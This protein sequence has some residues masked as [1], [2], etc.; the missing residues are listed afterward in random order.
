M[1]NETKKMRLFS[2]INS[3]QLICPKID[4]NM[5]F[6]IHILNRFVLRISGNTSVFPGIFID[7]IPSQ[8]WAVPSFSA[9]SS[10]RSKLTNFTTCRNPEP[11]TDQRERGFRKYLYR[12]LK[13]FMVPSPLKQRL[14]IRDFNAKREEQML[15]S[16]HRCTLG[17]Q[18]EFHFG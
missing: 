5:Y 16:F 11:W 8:F 14:S 1:L 2:K 12:G 18:F 9:S 13:Y 15:P 10:L 3:Y 6:S 17:S 7:H 4:H